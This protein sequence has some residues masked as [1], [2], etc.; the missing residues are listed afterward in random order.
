MAAAG[1]MTPVPGFQEQAG[2]DE[3]VG[4]EPMVFVGELGLEPDRAGVGIDLVV[5]GQQDNRVASFLV[6]SRFI[7]LHRQ[8]VPGLEFIEHRREVVLGDGKHD[9]DGLQL[10]DH[11]QPGGI[12]GV[13]DVARIHRRRP[14]RP[15]DGGGDAAIS[16]LQL[17][18]VDLPLVELDGALELVHQGFLGIIL[19]FGD[20]VLAGQGPVALADP[21]GRFAA[22]PGRGPSALRAWVNCA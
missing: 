13:N 16:Q 15:A 5:E 21:A 22:R 6:C 11:G 2:I 3:L 20:G 10:G 7:G 1:T 9:R 19:L 4:E 17:G 12:G 18:V 8:A 14:I